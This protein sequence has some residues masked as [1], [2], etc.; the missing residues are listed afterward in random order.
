MKRLIEIKTNDLTMLLLPVATKHI[1]HSTNHHGIRLLKILALMA[2]ER[3]N[4]ENVSS[5]W[6]N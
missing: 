5:I 1:Q 6:G 2:G 3:Y 4:G